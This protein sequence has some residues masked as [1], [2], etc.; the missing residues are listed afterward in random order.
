HCALLGV[1]EEGI[2][3]NSREITEI[4]LRSG[5]YQIQ[6]TSHL[7]PYICHAISKLTNKSKI[8][9]FRKK[10]RRF[11]CAFHFFCIFADEKT[12]FNKEM[13]DYHAEYT[14]QSA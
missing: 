13:D 2:R 9:I 8:P 4:Y 14:K 5:K 6:G 11:F 10:Q 12:K 7:F 3:G 1:I